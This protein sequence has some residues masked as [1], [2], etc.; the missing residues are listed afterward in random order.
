[1]YF[2]RRIG[3]RLELVDMVVPDHFLTG[4][5]EHDLHVMGGLVFRP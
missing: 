3:A 5:A 4:R 2:G 1:V